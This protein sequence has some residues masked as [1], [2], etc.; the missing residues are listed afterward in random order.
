MWYWARPVSNSCI[1]FHCHHWLGL[2]LLRC[3]RKKVLVIRSKRFTIQMQFRLCRGLTVR[4]RMSLVTAWT[5]HMTAHIVLDWAADCSRLVVLRQQR[6]C[7]QN[8]CPSDWQWVFKRRQN[9][10]V[11]HRYRRQA[12]SRRPTSSDDWCCSESMSVFSHLFMWRVW[13]V[14]P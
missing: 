4:I 12:D 9:P 8:C 1:S 11:W 3:T 14:E 13:F 7:F 2:I 6:S 10:V 5:G